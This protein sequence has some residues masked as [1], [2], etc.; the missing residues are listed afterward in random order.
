[1][2]FATKSCIPQLLLVKA[3]SDLNDAEKCFR[4]RYKNANLKKQKSDCDALIEKHQSDAAL[5]VVVAQLIGTL[6]DR[7]SS[8]I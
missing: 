2:A 6:R 1:M 7:F 5:L 4:F 8:D 3:E